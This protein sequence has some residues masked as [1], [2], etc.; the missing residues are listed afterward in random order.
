MIQG[1]DALRRHFNSSQ[2]AGAHLHV[3]SGALILCGP[4]Q[5]SGWR[6][7]AST[8]SSPGSS[9]D[10]RTRPAAISHRRLSCLSWTVPDSRSD[11]AFHRRGAPTALVY[12]T[13]IRAAVRMAVGKGLLS[14]VVNTTVDERDETAGCTLAARA[15]VTAMQ[16]ADCHSGP[17]YSQQR[18]LSPQ[19]GSFQHISRV[20]PN[21]RFIDSSSR[22][23]PSHRDACLL[24][25]E[26]PVVRG[27]KGGGRGDAVLGRRDG[28]QRHRVIF[29]PL[30]R[31]GRSLRT[32]H[33][34]ICV[35]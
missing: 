3:S 22:S 26:D 27:R 33:W 8:P 24:Q 9:A 12:A 11:V 6:V 4:L 16:R 21:I 17:S 18:I 28:G 2:P 32:G 35:I 15:A 7:D 23:P 30:S 14:C 31:R 1:E 20:P 10:S 13:K 19:R 25:Q 29:A 5:H 34:V